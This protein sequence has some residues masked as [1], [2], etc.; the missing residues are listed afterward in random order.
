M[1]IFKGKWICRKEFLN[2]TPLNVFHREVNPDKD[3]THR[4]NLKN[5][6]TLFKRTFDFKGAK[7][8]IIR[9]TA[10]DYFKLYTIH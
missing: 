2:L 7:K 3:Y 4:D 6:H 10:D 1:S 8:A 5:I 9:L